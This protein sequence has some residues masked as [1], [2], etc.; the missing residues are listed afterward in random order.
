[1]LLQGYGQQM[2]DKAISTV[3]TTGALTSKTIMIILV[4]LSLVGG[5]I[6]GIIMLSSPSIENQDAINSG[7]ALYLSTPEKALD[8]FIEAIK[9]NNVEEVK[10]IH[11]K[12]ENP[13]IVDSFYDEFFEWVNPGESLSYALFGVEADELTA[14]YDYD[15]SDYLGLVG[16]GRTVSSKETYDKLYTVDFSV[17]SN[18]GYSIDLVLEGNEWRLIADPWKYDFEHESLFD[19][20][21]KCYPPNINHG[22][23]CCL[24]KNSNDICDNDEDTSIKCNDTDGGK[25]YYVKGA[26]TWL[27]NLIPV[28]NTDNCDGNRLTEWYCTGKISYSCQY[29]CENGACIS[30]GDYEVKR[31]WVEKD[32]WTPSNFVIYSEIVDNEDNPALSPTIEVMMHFTNPI[33]SSQ[34]NRISHIYQNISYGEK[35]YWGYV[36]A[37]TGL[38]QYCGNYSVNLTIVDTSTPNYVTS[39]IIP[40]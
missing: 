38:F 19:A 22:S 27:D 10:K 39:F 5:V 17:G 30:L 35:H 40:C 25:N 16:D 6:F 9:T 37:R 18:D 12:K 33:N 11:S 7:N 28:T 34:T 2:V 29:G 32:P 21:G 1:M 13:E 8:A 31:V 3:Y 26:I 20:T 24:D 23:S 14:V 36:F 4:S 15:Y